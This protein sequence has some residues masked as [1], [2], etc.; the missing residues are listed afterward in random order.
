[1][2]TRDDFIQESPD[3]TEKYTGEAAEIIK[4]LKRN[5]G[6]RINTA[7]ELGISKTTHT[8]KMQ[9]LGITEDYKC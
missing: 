1:M 5:N 2:V 9:K 8:R 7:A 6:N 3:D 4:A